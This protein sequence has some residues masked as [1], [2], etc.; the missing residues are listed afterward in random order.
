MIWARQREASRT[1]AVYRLA[2]FLV[3]LCVPSVS[4]LEGREQITGFV[5]V[6]GMTAII[7]I[8]LPSVLRRTA[9]RYDAIFEAASVF[10]CIGALVMSCAF[11][12]GIAVMDTAKV[13]M[14]TY[15]STHPMQWAPLIVLMLGFAAIPLVLT[16]YP[17][18]VTLIV[19]FRCVRFVDRANLLDSDQGLNLLFPLMLCGLI[20]IFSAFVRN[21]SLQREYA[22]VVRT[23]S[24]ARNGTR[25]EEEPQ[26]Q[27]TAANADSYSNLTVVFADIA[28]FTGLSR[29]V[30]PGHL[31][32]ILNDIFHCADNCAQANGLERVKTIG[33]CYMAVAG[34]V[35]SRTTTSA[36]V[37]EFAR[38]YVHAFKALPALEHLGLAV[39]IGIHTGPAVG[40]FIG[41]QRREYDYWGDTVNLA[42]RLEGCAPHNGLAM[43]ETT[44][45]QVIKQFP[46]PVFEE[47]ELKGVGVSRV[48]R[49]SI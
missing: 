9:P 16:G 47:I 21:L 18:L 15:S 41:G 6:T 42:S 40:G 5:I 4:L 14:L 28:G 44:Y 22:V 35:V 8:S 12:N 36:D 32:D 19:I 3:I 31:V 33:D 25:S 30:S 27:G 24:L 11:F 13:P 45:L 39:R 49:C 48:L 43:S 2:A 20:A 38:S 46:E 7:L 34:G 29:R 37:V 1:A 10:V 26:A 17:L 23:E